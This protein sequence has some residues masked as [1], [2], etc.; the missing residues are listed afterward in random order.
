MVQLNYPNLI[1]EA[2]FGMISGGLTWHVG[3]II[4]LGQRPKAGISNLLSAF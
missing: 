2:L 1:K 3:N 4:V